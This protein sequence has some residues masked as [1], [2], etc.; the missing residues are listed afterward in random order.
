MSH[1]HRVVV[2][3]AGFGGLAVA[4][5][6]RHTA[7]DVVVI[8]ANNFHTFQPLLYQVATAGLGGD[9]IAYAVRGIFRRQRNVTFRMA[10]VTGIDL[11]ARVLQLSAG[12]PLGYDTLVV[13]AGAVSNSYD[14]P[15]VDEHAFTLKSVEDAVALRNHVL[16]KFEA[17][18]ADP[19]AM[20]PAALSV[21]VCGGG[22]TGVEMAGGMMELFDHVL[23]KDFPQL[24]V[25]RA[26]V[27]LVEAADRLLGTFSTASGERARRTLTRRGVEVVTGIGVDRIDASSVVLAD[28]RRID[29]ATVVWA[30]GVR[31]NPLAS[32]LGVPLGRGGRIVVGPDL[33]V[34][35]HPE[36]FAIGDIATDA[37]DPLPQVA[38]P[39]IQ[40]GH[41]VAR[42][43]ARQLA[44][45]PTQAF[46]YTDKG[47]MATIGRH[48]AVAELAN[49]M[50]LSGTLGWLAWLGLHIVYLMG[51]RNRANVLV[52]WTWN[53]LTYDR[54]A[55][56]LTEDDVS[57]PQPT[58]IS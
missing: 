36:V 47:S 40:G 45:Q 44:G 41:H 52:N 28:G 6:L 42:Q 31:A 51:F 17:A 29:A 16:G 54:A 26:R 10:R 15:G 14:V 4:R 13:A 57:R 22:P 38:Q 7:V 50:R 20:D 21:V 39:A 46:R 27:V 1:R 24:D 48:D 33:A 19:A 25:R 32:M 43:I 35:E 3:G 23:A 5:S 30:A 12:Q 49:G 8:D 53:Y 11:D 37:A 2:I 18:S 58:D 34:P 56:L 55:R 9:D